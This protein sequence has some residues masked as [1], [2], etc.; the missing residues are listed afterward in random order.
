MLAFDQRDLYTGEG[1]RR[2]A[3]RT[4]NQLQDFCW[5]QHAIMPYCSD[6]CAELPLDSRRDVKKGRW[7]VCPWGCFSRKTVFLHRILKPREMHSFRLFSV[8]AVINPS[9][10]P[11]GMAGGTIISLCSKAANFSLWVLSSTIL[12]RFLWKV[13]VIV[14]VIGRDGVTPQ[15]FT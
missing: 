14:V 8:A 11:W 5:Q 9:L 6:T 3:R 10:L 4:S 1:G 2:P 13:W 7:S 15:P 12:D